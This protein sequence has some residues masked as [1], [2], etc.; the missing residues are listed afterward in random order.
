MKI[1]IGADH[2]GFE[3]KQ[4]IIDTMASIDWLDVGAFNKERS[5]FPIFSKDVCKAIIQRK[6][7][8]G[9]LLCGSGIGMSI[10]ANR[11]QQIYAALVWNDAVAKSSKEHNHA[12]VLVFPADY[13]S[14]EDAVRMIKIWLAAEEFP[15]RYQERIDMI[16]DLV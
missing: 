4:S 8:Y 12:N 6:A 1:A 3:H 9:I 14:S 2:R 15:G 13:I 7:E 11:Y 16:D 5:D 10:A